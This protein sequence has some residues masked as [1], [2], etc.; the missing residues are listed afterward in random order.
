VESFQ[1]VFHS[2]AK[3]NPTLCHSMNSKRYSSFVIY[4]KIHLRQLLENSTTIQSMEEIF[5]A[6]IAT[7]QINQPNLNIN[8][9]TVKLQLKTQCIGTK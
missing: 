4:A 8:A 7:Y 5:G 2:S 3:K 6:A 9:Q 1:R